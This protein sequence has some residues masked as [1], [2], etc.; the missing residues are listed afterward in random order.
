MCVV[1]LFDCLYHLCFVFSFYKN[2]H[3]LDKG[4][5]WE[6]LGEGEEYDKNILHEN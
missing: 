1:V 5:I 6:E 2:D 4:R 3:E